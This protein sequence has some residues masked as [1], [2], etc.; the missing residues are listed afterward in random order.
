MEIP[1]IIVSFT[2]LLLHE[3]KL[4]MF[5]FEISFYIE[6]IPSFKI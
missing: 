1:V 6:I 5:D 4:K 3:N 2:S